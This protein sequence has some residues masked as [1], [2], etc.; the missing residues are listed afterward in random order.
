MVRNEAWNKT[1]NKD[2]NGCNHL[3]EKLRIIADL[4]FTN[5]DKAERMRLP[6]GIRKTGKSVFKDCN[7]LKEVYIGKD[8]FKIGESPFRGCRLLRKIE[9]AV[10]NRYFRTD[11]EDHAL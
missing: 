5:C 11:E 10:N 9:A 8:T 7:I 3:P 1:D 2:E 6:D 4:A